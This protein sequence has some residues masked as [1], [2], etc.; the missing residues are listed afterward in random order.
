MWCVD[1]PTRTATKSNMLRTDSDAVL[2]DQS[3]E[4]K[5]FR[6]RYS[7]VQARLQRPVASVLYVIGSHHH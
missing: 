4:A 5:V 7:H 6:L 2:H 1:E 3:V